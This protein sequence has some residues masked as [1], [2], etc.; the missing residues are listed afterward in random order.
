MKVSEFRDH[1]TKAPEG[2]LCFILPD[3]GRIP[4]HAHITE[5][6]RTDRRFLDCGGTIRSVSSCTLQAW[7]AEDTEHRL[8]PG[9]LITILGKAA[10]V[11][12]TDDLEVEIEYEDGFLS[13]FPVVEA[14]QAE[15]LLLFRLG[16]K[17]TDC[18]AKEICLPQAG[19]CCATE[20]CC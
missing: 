2:E 10:P 20:G 8:L 3:G 18:L 1:L 9:S 14:N 19:S 15:G 7:V 4:V 13:Q 11:L 12:E 16:T 17:H 6:G 5:V